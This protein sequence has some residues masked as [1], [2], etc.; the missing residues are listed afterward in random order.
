MSN[1]VNAINDV[2]D[3]D[4]VLANLIKFLSEKGLDGEYVSFLEDS[5]QTEKLYL[6]TLD[7]Q[8]DTRMTFVVMAPSELEAKKEVSANINALGR[9]IKAWKCER[10]AGRVL[11]VSGMGK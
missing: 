1:I 6:C 10:Q 7:D 11:A 5:N 2:D 8:H 9:T 3:K 4:Y